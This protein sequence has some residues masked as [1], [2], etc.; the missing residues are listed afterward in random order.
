MNYAGSKGTLGWQAPEILAAADQAE[1]RC[2][3]DGEL[4][5]VR[6]TKKVDIFSMGA[7]SSIL[8]LGVLHLLIHKKGCLVYFVLTNGLHP[9]G[10]SYEREANV[11]KNQP[12]IHPSLPPEAR[13]LVF[14]M[15][16]HNPTKRCAF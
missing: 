8:P 6:V 13:N 10:P 2:R 11:R 16:E 7:L 5:P 14:S 1:A 12:S 4:K 3:R 9:F 15:I